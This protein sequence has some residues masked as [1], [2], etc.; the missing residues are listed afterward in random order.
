MFGV[1]GLTDS[2]IAA[3]QFVTC[4]RTGRDGTGCDDQNAFHATSTQVFM[5]AA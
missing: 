4:D 3:I 1:K 5:P 2:Q